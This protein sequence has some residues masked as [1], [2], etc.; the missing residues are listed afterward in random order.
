MLDAILHVHQSIHFRDASILDKNLT[1]KS[2]TVHCFNIYISDII[3]DL[4]SNVDSGGVC[5]T[6]IVP[7]TAGRASDPAPGA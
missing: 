5:S 6:V 4:F 3:T 7:W 2:R 1:T